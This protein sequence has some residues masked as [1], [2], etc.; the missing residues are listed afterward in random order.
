[1]VSVAPP[2]AAESSGG[3]VLTAGSG[4]TLRVSDG[5]LE[6]EVRPGHRVAALQDLLDRQV[7]DVPELRAHRSGLLRLL[8]EQAEQAWASGAAYCASMAEPTPDGPITASVVVLVVPGPLGFLDDDPE[9]LA[10]LAAPLPPIPDTGDETPWRQTSTVHVDGAGAAVRTAGVQ[11]VELPDGSGAVHMVLMQT[12]VPLPHARTLVL[13]CSSPVVAL[14]GELLDL[15][16]AVSDTLH[17]VLPDRLA[18]AG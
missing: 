6:L 2:G 17:V 4:F 8:R 15:F 7:R 1:M 18:V 16:D 14:A 13:T 12:L 11:D 10:A 3:P 9:R 5:W